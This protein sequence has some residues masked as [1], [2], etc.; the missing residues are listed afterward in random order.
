MT[1]IAHCRKDVFSVCLT[2]DLIV[3]QAFLGW[4]PG[5]AVRWEVAQEE[6]RGCRIVWG[7]VMD[8]G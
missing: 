1:Y 2:K 7:R 5:S 6:P 3:R 8:D 4:L